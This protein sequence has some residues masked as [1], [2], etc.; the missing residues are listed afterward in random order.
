M[1]LPSNFGSAPGEE[2]HRYMKNACIEFRKLLKATKDI[3]EL[4]EG[5]Q[6]IIDTGKQMNWHQKNEWHLPQGRRCQNS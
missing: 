5:M 1:S 2:L 4:R 3:G 6:K